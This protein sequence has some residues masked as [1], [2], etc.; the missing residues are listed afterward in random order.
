MTF[1]FCLF[2]IMYMYSAMAIITSQCRNGRPVHSKLR[3]HLFCHA[4]IWRGSQKG[5]SKCARNES[6]PRDESYLHDR[7]DCQG[8]PIPLYC[9]LVNA[10]ITSSVC[11]CSICC[12]VNP[13]AEKSLTI[14][15]LT[16]GTCRELGFD[17]PT[18]RKCAERA[19]LQSPGA[20]AMWFKQALAVLYR[21]LLRFDVKTCLPLDELG[22]AFGL[23]RDLWVAIEE[24]HRLAL[25]AH[26]L[27]RFCGIGP[28][29]A[30][31]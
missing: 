26:M 6:I 1:C 28:M 7:Y 11:F 15:C 19:S 16:K 5:I 9:V 30:A 31:A 29:L 25:H 4:D 23:T 10:H 21:Y 24:Q 12:A 27:G 14:I 17:V 13:R 22:G 3:D 18:I 2:Y 20:V 8:L